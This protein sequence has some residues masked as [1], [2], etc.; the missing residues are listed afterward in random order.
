ME[1]QAVDIPARDCRDEVDPVVGRG[2]DD[3][4]IVRNGMIGVDEID[5]APLPDAGEE[6]RGGDD[7]ELTT[8][9]LDLLNLPLQT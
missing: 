2:G 7:L 1:L 9:C 8:K 6:R 4:V 5:V 3:G